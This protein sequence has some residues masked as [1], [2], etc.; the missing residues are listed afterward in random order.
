MQFFSRRRQ[1]RMKVKVWED[2]KKKEEYM[3]ERGKKKKGKKN[4]KGRD[5][6]VCSLYISFGVDAAVLGVGQSALSH[7]P[8]KPGLRTSSGELGQ[9][10]HLDHVHGRSAVDQQRIYIIVDH[11]FLHNRLR[12]KFV[13]NIWIVQIFS[14]G[15]TERER[16]KYAPCVVH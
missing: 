14:G 8:Q 16:K 7:T 11:K 4:E 10:S 9:Q 2:E 15:P 5:F 13:P 1:R 6:G 12:V 3:Y